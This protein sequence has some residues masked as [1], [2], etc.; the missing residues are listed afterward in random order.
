M[1]LFTVR[2][3]IVKS[4]NF[5]VQMNALDA[6]MIS[7]GFSKTVVD[8]AGTRFSLPSGEYIFE[9]NYNIEKV[10]AIVIAATAKVDEIKISFLINEVVDMDWDGLTVYP[11][12]K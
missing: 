2:I 12:L 11:F 1:A 7:E 10:R 9:R 3:D 5:Q 6:A 8:I 4:I